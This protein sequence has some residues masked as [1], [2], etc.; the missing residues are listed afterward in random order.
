MRGVDHALRVDLEVESV[1]GLAGIVRMAV[2]GLLPVY[3]LAH[4][5]D[6]GFAFRNI[7]HGENTFAVHA[8]APGL[9]AAAR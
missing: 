5:L 9:D 4:V 6:D 8:G 3:D 1:I 7:L 2:L